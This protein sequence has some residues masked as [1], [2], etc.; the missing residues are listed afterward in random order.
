L[1]EVTVSV[2]GL[3][4]PLRVSMPSTAT[5]LSPSKTTLVDLKVAVG[6]F[7]VSRKSSPWM[8]SSKT[9]E[10]VSTDLVSITMSTAAG[11]GSLVEDDLAGRLVEAAQ[12]GRIAEVVV[13][14]AR[15]GVVAVDDVGFRLGQRR[16]RHAAARRG[17]R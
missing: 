6:Y 13:R 11:L 10:P 17:R 16:R 4:T 2:T 5:G 8:C 14:E 3:V 7:A 9:A 12:L 1:N 15:E